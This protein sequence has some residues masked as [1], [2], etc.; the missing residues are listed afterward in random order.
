MRLQSKNPNTARFLDRVYSHL[1][2]HD[3][4][5]KVLTK[6]PKNQLGFCGYFEESDRIIAIVKQRGWLE[7]LAHEYGH[8]LQWKYQHPSYR[9]C[10]QFEHDPDSTIEGWVKGR[11]YSSKSLKRAFN[12]VRLNEIECEILTCKLIKYYDLPINLDRYRKKVNLDIV[13]YHWV[14]QTR[15]WDQCNKAHSG[16]LGMMPSKIYRSFHK[17]VPHYLLQAAL[18]KF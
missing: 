7:V 4:Q 8:F 1:A 18:N 9:K 16:L 13:F 14:Q 10:S 17:E 11:Q 12:A 2:R 3:F 6:V 5:I 15:Q